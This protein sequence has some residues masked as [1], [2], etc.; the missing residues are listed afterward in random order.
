MKPG[1]HQMS[2]AEYQADPC[3]TASLSS[4]N[5]G[6]L[7]SQSALHAWFHHPKLNPEYKEEHDDKFDLGA[8]AHALLLEGESSIAVIEAADW[9]KQAA[10]DERDA[11]RTNGKIPVLAHKMAECRTMAE[12]ARN[13]LANCE[14]VKIKLDEGVAERVL[15]WQETDIWCRARPD[16]MKNDHTLMLDYKSTAGSAEPAA[17]SRTQ[18]VPM[19]YD[20]Q[21]AHYVRGVQQTTKA[22]P[23]FVFLVQENYAPYA[24]SF[25][26]CDSAMLE[27]AER[28]RDFAVQLWRSC[29]THGSWTGYPQ[30]IAYAEP[31]AWQ[32]AEAE[33]ADENFRR[34]IELGGQG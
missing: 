18:M 4:G 32:L 21:A 1:I 8:C 22:R 16:W 14:D 34:M 7:L 19:G 12:I 27:I 30:R 24:C 10:K 17:W 20:L 3:P 15:V 9:R 31:T 5:A 23:L 33:G 2:M 28:K 6:R 11:A 13:A 29:M 26:S 25:V